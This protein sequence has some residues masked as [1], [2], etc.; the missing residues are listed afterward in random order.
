MTSSIEDRLGEF[1]CGVSKLMEIPK[2]QMEYFADEVVSNVK[3]LSGTVYTR[4]TYTDFIRMFS[5]TI[6]EAKKYSTK[7]LC[8]EI[9]IFAA[10][11]AS[12][13][14]AREAMLKD[15][16]FRRVLEISGDKK[17]YN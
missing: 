6:D 10:E 14:L 13:F 12:F 8:E 9:P 4:E 15:P 3:E 16:L 7:D 11:M 1:I 5:E 17:T 2:E